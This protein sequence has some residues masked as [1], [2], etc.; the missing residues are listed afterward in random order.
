MFQVGYARIDITPA[1]SVPLAGYGNTAKRMSNNVLDPLY[2]TCTAL[3][4]ENGTTVMLFHND[5]INAPK[6]FSLPA[7]QAVSEATGLPLENIL[8][9]ATHTHSGPDMYNLAVP[10]LVR[11]N[12]SLPAKLVQCAKEALAERKNVTAAYSA[13]VFT[14][15]LNFVRHYILEDGHYK[16]S[17]FGSQY[18]SPIAGHTTEADEEMR[19][20]K[21]VRQGGKDVLLTNWQVHP[22]CTAGAEKPDISSDIIGAFR[23]E[24]EEALDCHFTYF[25]GGA[26]NLSHQSSIRSENIASGHAD[27]GRRL[28]DHA[29]TAEYKPL[30]LGTI[31]VQFNDYTEPLNRPDPSQVEAAQKVTEYWHS[32]EDKATVV[33]FAVEHGFSS[34]YAAAL[35]L[36]KHRME[37]DIVEVPL[38]AISMGDF[39]FVTTPCEMFDTNMKYVRDF[40]PF[41]MTF[42]STCTNGGIPY[43]PSAY[44]FIHDCYEAAMSHCKPGAAERVATIL[45]NMLK[46]AKE[47]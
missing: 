40:S 46:R 8:F 6:H 41:P 19:L 29:L 18:N 31:T 10:S 32:A 21:F 38:T 16:G 30:A 45:V 34:Q 1:E 5:V 13:K 33:P 35:L 24:M 26:G 11:Y 7:R 12:E 27:F 3:T 37:S 22:L 36:I 15:N 25:V 42:V 2:S 43:I 14:K 28:K 20:V 17:N 9:C 44:A 23:K 47:Q 4:D 39:G